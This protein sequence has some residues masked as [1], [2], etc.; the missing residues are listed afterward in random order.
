M[1]ISFSPHAWGCSGG[2][3]FGLAV[4]A[5]EPSRHLLRPPFRRVGLQFRAAASRLPYSREEGRGQLDEHRR[6][7]DEPEKAVGLAPDTPVSAK[8]CPQNVDVRVRAKVDRQAR[9]IAADSRHSFAERGLE[10]RRT[11][12]RGRVR[13]APEGRS[14]APNPHTPPH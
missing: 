11:L 1:R 5:R 7:E 2:W 8:C 4:V 9:G 3:R 12:A 13:A 10:A 14:E 6:D